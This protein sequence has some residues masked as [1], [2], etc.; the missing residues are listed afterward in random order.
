[1]LFH[2]TLILNNT[3][4]SI[5]IKTRFNST[6][7]TKTS[8]NGH[9]KENGLVLMAMLAW[10]VIHG[11]MYAHKYVRIAHG[12]ITN[13]T[14]N[15]RPGSTQYAMFV[16]TFDAVE[17]WWKDIDTNLSSTKTHPINDWVNGE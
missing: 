15:K 8:H 16:N 17:I 11:C 6:E 7:S 3:E 12:L 9:L 14:A 2:D 13:D 5:A 1:M 10:D 4:Y